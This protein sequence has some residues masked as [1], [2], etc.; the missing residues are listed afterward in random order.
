M[1]Y[2]V[3]TAGIFCLDFFIKRK[4]DRNRKVDEEEAICHNRIIL[5]K[6][7]NKGAVLNLLAKHPKQ[8]TALHSFILGAIT[9]IYGWS[10]RHKEH[11]GVRLGLAM[12]T[13]GGL[14]NLHDRLTK[15]HV[16]DYFR[17]NTRFLRI[18]NII[19]NISDLFVFLG[20]MLL[21]VFGRRR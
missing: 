3:I 8:M 21:M 14:S 11:T 1:I 15:H 16:V 6:Y 12:I 7:Y 9:A 20:S 19:F 17:I 4:I 2:I 18:R 10:L 13:G 5:T